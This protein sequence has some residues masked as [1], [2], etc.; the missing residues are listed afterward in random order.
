MYIETMTSADSIYQAVV[1]HQ[2][3]LIR[4]FR[5]DGKLTF[6]NGAFCRFYGMESEALLGSNFRDLLDPE[7]CDSI[8]EQVLSISPEK[9]EIVT[10][11]RYVDADGRLRFVQ[12]VTRGIFDEFGNVVEYQS[13]GRDI[14]AQREAETTLAEARM[15]MEKA[16]RVTTL[17]V[18]GGGIAHEINQPL[19]ALRILTASAQLLAERADSPGEDLARILRDIAAQVDRADAIVNHLREHLRQNQKVDSKTCDLGDAV[20]SALSLVGAQLAARDIG[21]DLHIDADLPPV[22]GSCIRFEELVANLVAN[23]MQ[24]M[25]EVKLDQKEIRVEVLGT[26]PGS[27]ELTVADNGPGFAREMTAKMFEPFFSTKSSGTSMGLGLS[28]VE[29]I[30]QAAG[31]SVTAI[32]R[33]EGGALIEVLLPAAGGAGE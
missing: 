9:P 14:T 28:I 20:R 22:N 2:T 1:E 11:P 26:T 24:A 21:V 33:P 16:S 5:P 15:A 13:V 7:E 6:V 25:D 29:T 19:N 12:Y 4:R 30:V 10:E 8:V 18:I 17:A 27:V 31:G 23:A 3:E 32:N